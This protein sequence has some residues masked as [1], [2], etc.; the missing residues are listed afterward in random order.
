MSCSKIEQLLSGHRKCYTAKKGK[1]S[2][3]KRHKG[4]FEGAFLGGRYKHIGQGLK[5]AGR[6]VSVRVDSKCGFP[7]PMLSRKKSPR[8]D[9]GGGRISKF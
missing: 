3:N 4:G 8:H 5:M 9:K 6:G 7:F 1:V 2:E